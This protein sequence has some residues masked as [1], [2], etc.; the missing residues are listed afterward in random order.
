MTNKPYL[1]VNELRQETIVN[2]PNET[3]YFGYTPIY[4]VKSV[5]GCTNEN[6]FSRSSGEVDWNKLDTRDDRVEIEGVFNSADI[7]TDL[8]NVKVSNVVMQIP[9][10]VSDMKDA[11]TEFHRLSVGGGYRG[12]IHEN[13]L[14][15]KA[16]FD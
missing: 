16:H 15:V 12:V 2:R 13:P 6:L 5:L 10:D 8:L 1:D 4:Q 9:D 14:F 3:I 7:N 11:I